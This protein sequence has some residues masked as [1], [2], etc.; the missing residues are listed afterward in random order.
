LQS[1]TLS[2]CSEEVAGTLTISLF[3]GT[4]SG[5]MG[6]AFLVNYDDSDDVDDDEE[7]EEKNGA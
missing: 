7:E 6:L 3:R 2:V 4:A 1:H 5:R